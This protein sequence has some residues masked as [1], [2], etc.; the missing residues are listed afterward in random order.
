MCRCVEQPCDADEGDR[1]KKV[2]C[3]GRYS[4]ENDVPAIGAVRVA[5]A[6]EDGLGRIKAEPAVRGNGRGMAYAPGSTVGRGRRA[7]VSRTLGC[8]LT[9]DLAC[10]L[11][12]RSP[13][14]S[15]RNRWRISFANPPYA[16]TASFPPSSWQPPFRPSSS[17]PWPSP[18]QPAHSLFPPSSR[19]RAACFPRSGPGQNCRRARR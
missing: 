6:G 17:L 19:G 16:P 5:S 15:W 9:D 11:W 18:P 3:H 7:V 1:E 10:V 8:A 14:M 4:R 13:P 12:K 2:P